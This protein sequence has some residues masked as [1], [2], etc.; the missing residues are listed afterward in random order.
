MKIAVSST[1]SNLD[2]P[3]SPIFGRCPMYLMVDSETLA[4]EAV[5]N[6]AMSAGGGAGIQAAQFVVAQGAKAVL[7][8]NVGP[9]AFEVFRAAGVS[10]FL[11]GT[12]TVREA[13]QA[14]RD[15]T[16]PQAGGASASAHAGM[17]GIRL[18]S[19]GPAPVQAAAPALSGAS[20]AR[21]AEI[22]D[23]QQTARDL[24]ERLVEVMQ[25]LDRLEQEEV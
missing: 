21:A 7:T 1:G 12:G 22:A 25:R 6:P 10:V 20:E 17:G 15:G 18:A 3:A 2:A 8:G 5:E 4:Y 23:L 16:L 11:A 14:F 19:A 24:R 9:N 13:V